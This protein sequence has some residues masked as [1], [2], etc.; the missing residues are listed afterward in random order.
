MQTL[1][2]QLEG[3]ISNLNPIPDPVSVTSSNGLSELPDEPEI[4]S[5]LEQMVLHLEPMPDDNI[6]KIFGE[7]TCDLARYAVAVWVDELHQDS[8][9]DEVHKGKTR[10]APRIGE[11]R[12]E[13]LHR[14]NPILSSWFNSLE[15]PPTVSNPLRHYFIAPNGGET[16]YVVCHSLI[17][18]IA[19]G[20][21][22]CP[23]P[24][25][26]QLAEVYVK[27][28]SLGFEGRHDGARGKSTRDKYSQELRGEVDVIPGLSKRKPKS[29]LPPGARDVDFVLKSLNTRKALRVP[30]EG[31]D[32]FVDEHG[33][34]LG[35]QLEGGSAVVCFGQAT[36]AQLSTTIE[37]QDQRE[38][39]V[40]QGIALRF[41]LLIEGQLNENYQIAENFWVEGVQAQRVS[42]N[43]LSRSVLDQRKI[44]LLGLP[45]EIAPADQGAF[46]GF[47]LSKE[48]PPGVAFLSQRNAWPKD[49][50]DR[51]GSQITAVHSALSD[52]RASHTD[53]GMVPLYYIAN[54]VQ[55]VETDRF[56]VGL[57]VDRKRIDDAYKNQ[58]SGGWWFFLPTTTSPWLTAD[59]DS[60]LDEMI[61]SPIE[62]V[63]PYSNFD[64]RKLKIGEWFRLTHHLAGGIET[65]HG[66]GAIHGDIRPANI[67]KEFGG[68]IGSFE[69]IDLGMGAQPGGYRTQVGG[70]RHTFFY[71]RDRAETFQFEAV[72]SAKIELSSDSL[73]LK[74]TLQHKLLTAEAPKALRL[75]PVGVKDESH[76]NEID[77]RGGNGGLRTVLSDLKLGDRI[78]IRNLLFEVYSVQPDH[79]I[80][81]RVDE[82]FLGKF[83]H[84]LDLKVAAASYSDLP[85]AKLNILFKWGQ[86]SDV[87][88]FGVVVLYM[89]FMRGVWAMRDL[90][91]R[92]KVPINYTIVESLVD[93]F[94]ELVKS[95][96]NQ[97]KL[98]LFL[99][100]FHNPSRTPEEID[101]ESKYSDIV[102]EKARDVFAVKSHVVRLIQTSPS[103]D[104]LDARKFAH[105]SQVVDQ[106]LRVEGY[107]TVVYWGVNCSPALFAMLIYFVL[108]CIW[109]RDEISEFK[110]QHL[111]RPIGEIEFDAFAHT[112]EYISGSAEVMQKPIHEAALVLRDIASTVA[113]DSSVSGPEPPPPPQFDD[114]SEPVYLQ[115]VKAQMQRRD[116]QR[117]RDKA[118]G[119]QIALESALLGLSSK[120]DRAV[121][122]LKSIAE[123][124]VTFTDRLFGELSRKEVGQIA[125]ILE[126]A[127]SEVSKIVGTDETK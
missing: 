82:I 41:P 80:V 121:G 25:A 33:V 36:G 16:F 34:I 70:G 2:A 113:E 40:R 120:V 79:L 97:T 43:A 30:V 15:V 37:R 114:Y 46:L 126:N 44:P 50:A 71:S 21:A 17:R 100:F 69:W 86:A 31:G 105:L 12:I 13:P 14:D 67:M 66:D 38:N 32:L 101:P 96:K 1:L 62:R 125:T 64:F 5:K 81:K 106:C 103:L 93:A 55:P 109:R 18:Q 122:D 104:P 20:D 112:R 28:L 95:M 11:T 123:K 74:V 116:A 57:Q 6:Q 127:K 99:G 72:K 56:T 19:F 83:I 8:W 22:Q 84:R 9:D 89:F 47:Y 68:Q 49:F 54:T 90:R 39:F 118:N 63:S 53:Q 91:E 35:P 10:W 78:R 29:S 26:S 107:L 45:P 87:Y 124:E 59:L 7:L 110:F 61:D 23:L 77:V 4:L 102:F 76:N 117:E 75:R 48:E 73:S 119:R 85:V 52:A 60:M 3:V 51:L 115:L 94:D 24:G 108:R 98:D 92:Q 27:I 65:M 88:S 42:G 111:T 58:D